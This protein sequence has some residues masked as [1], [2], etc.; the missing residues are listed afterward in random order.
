MPHPSMLPPAKRHSVWAVRLR[1]IAQQN[2][3]NT[4]A[5]QLC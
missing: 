5:M 4:T 1:V 2:R 3:P